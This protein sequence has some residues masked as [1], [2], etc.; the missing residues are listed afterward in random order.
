MI[1][2]IPENVKNVDRQMEK[3]TPGWKIIIT[4]TWMAIFSFI[5]DSIEKITSFNFT[6]IFY[7][8]LTSYCSIFE[9]YQLKN[10]KPMIH[11]PLEH[12]W[13]IS[14]NWCLPLKSTTNCFLYLDYC[15]REKQPHKIYNM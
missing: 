8:P 10:P 4:Q 1:L 9:S 5:C 12:L 2:F 11:L 13:A 15:F 6:S 7:P 3:Q 14:F